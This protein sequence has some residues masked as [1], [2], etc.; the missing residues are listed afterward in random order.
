MKNVVPQKDG[1]MCRFCSISRGRV[2]QS[3]DTILGVS[4]GYFAIASVGALVPGWVLVCPTDHRLNMSRDYTDPNF[5]SVRLEIA[6]RLSRQ[7][8][9]PVRMFEHG[10]ACRSSATGC[11][12]DHAHLHLVPLR[13]RLSDAVSNL[14]DASA[15]HHVRASKLQESARDREYLF[16]SDD[17][18]AVDPMG[19]VR[20]LDEPVSQ[21][22]RK[23]IATQLGCDHE[24]DYRTH[25]NLGNV[26]ATTSALRAA[27]AH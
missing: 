3:Y 27:A 8:H 11:G 5:H 14:P 25:P 18:L 1:P 15:W 4:K 6:G 13:F 10:P 23:L 19:A 16:Y 24:F 21:F 9:S 7:F 26:T 12:V 20:L 17:A 22:F 2:E